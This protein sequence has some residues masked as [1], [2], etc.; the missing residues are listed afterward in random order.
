MNLINVPY[1]NNLSKCPI[2]V[3]AKY[4]KKPFKPVTNRTTELLGLIHTDWQI[5]KTLLVEEVK[6]I[7]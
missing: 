7:M 1:V 2:C 3:E 6:G 4:A 5:L